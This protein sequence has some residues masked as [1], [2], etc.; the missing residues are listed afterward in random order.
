M[1][2]T[3]TDG[4]TSP[5]GADIDHDAS[6]VVFHAN[7]KAGRSMYTAKLTLNGN[8]ASIG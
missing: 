7:S 3:G 1:I 8:T 2:A 5:G 6:H 4:L